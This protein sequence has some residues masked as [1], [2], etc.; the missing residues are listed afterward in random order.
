ML[1]KTVLSATDVGKIPSYYDEVTI[2][3]ADMIRL[4]DKK[5]VYLIGVNQG[6]FPT[7]A[8]ESSYF[9]AKDRETLSE[10]GLKTDAEC[11]VA[12]ARE[13][14]FFLRAFASANES[15]TLLY[16]TRNEAL[17]Q[18]EKADV[19]D[20]I[21]AICGELKPILISDIPPEE[22]IYFPA[23]AMEFMDDAEV[24]RA[25]SD[26]G[27]ADKIEI[28]KK[29]ISNLSSALTAD[30]VSEMYPDGISLTQT[31]IDSYV[32][33]PFAHFLRFN[34]RLSE[35]E[36][37]KFDSRNVG[38]FIHAI[39]ESF[40]GE[41]RKNKMTAGD[42][43]EAQREDM[44]RRAA[45]KYLDELGDMAASKRT[46]IL[47]D[48][49]SRAAKPVVDS[50]CDELSGSGFVP[51]FFELK[52]GRESEGLPS[53]A[54]FKT[55][56]GREVNVYGSIDRVDT[57]KRDDDVYV[58]VIDYKP[59]NKTF[60]P[61]D[62]DSGR[63]LQMFLYLKAVVESESPSFKDRLG[64][65]ENGR[66]I[67]A[68]VIYVKTDMSD[69]TIAHADPDEQ[70]K[71]IRKK[72]ERRGMLLSDDVSLGAMNKEYLPVKFKKDGTPDARSQKLL[73]TEEGWGELSEKVARKVCEVADGMC[74][75]NISVGGK[76][77]PCEYCSFKAICRK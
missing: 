25:L 58:R 4:T 28:S 30:I 2:G 71:A 51:E 52:I 32:G 41:L 6:E 56:S 62:L 74:A 73:Y 68:G 50:L 47:I 13:L 72:Q 54:R 11:D 66:I 20:R 39:L 49:L 36:V 64:V 27:Y 17:A 23:M 53:P 65:G 1:L 10:L 55:E 33:C 77:A 57:Y 75:G 24:E 35:D 37:A 70:E 42:V 26:V 38:S 16:S 45:K 5:H 44:I 40:F 69:V 43:D 63:N 18:A 61:D 9:T 7:P 3:A 21:S 12:Y 76:D 31:R 59:G 29:P 67:P 19:I 15:V 8:R 48:R 22:K 46:G 34:L 14:F 60:S